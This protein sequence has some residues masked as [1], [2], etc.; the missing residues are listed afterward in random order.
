[1]H[2]RLFW[3]VA[4]AAV[5]IIAAAATP[6]AASHPE[7]TSYAE[8]QARGDDWAE[9]GAD[10]TV[11]ARSRLGRDILQV[12]VGTGPATILVL[13]ALHAN[14]PSG[15]EASVR[16][17]DLLLGSAGSTFDGALSGV[18][19]DAP[20]VQALRDEDVREELL[21]RVTV[22]ALPMLDPDGVE[23]GHLREPLVNL[24]YATR[25]EPQSAAI[26]GAVRRFEPDLMLD[27]HGGP[28][29]PDLNIG[30]IEPDG[31]ET[32][33]A[34]ASV[35]AAGV[36]WRAGDALGIGL[37]Y[38][39]EWPLGLLLGRHDEPFRSADRAY[40]DLLTA[41]VPLT[42]ESYALEGLPVVYT[43]TVGLQS[44]APSISIREGASA[45]QVTAA[46]VILES[47]GLLTGQRP[48]REIRSGPG[49]TVEIAPGPGA[50]E[51][52]VVAR[53]GRGVAEDPT[54]VARDA[55]LTVRDARGVV[56][57]SSEAGEPSATRRSRAVAVP[58]L[59]GGPIRVE[60]RAS[61]VLDDMI[62]RVTWR[63]EDETVPKVPAGILG[64][65]SRVAYCLSESSRWDEI[66]PRFSGPSCTGDGG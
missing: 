15:T 9:R 32:A 65:P 2:R 28:D 25:L 62:V 53:W 23:A 22:V 37:S 52:Q 29:R 14:E 43:E 63:E 60:A 56:L 35:R 27:L 7:L 40:Y 36:A 19:P 50:R 61:G 5:A 45:Q 46:G 10:V 16:L 24:D 66:A 21:R 18:R 11:A 54:G 47:S 20:I 1:M 39:E 30:F 3:I 57:A 42:Q 51:L 8:L 17:V 49:G 6:A 55:E 59:P 13:G 48:R 64:D 4:T 38:F 44:R 31:V 26:G 58:E 34:R 33:V 12:R 41:V